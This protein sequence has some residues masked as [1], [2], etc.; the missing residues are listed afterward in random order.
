MRGAGGAIAALLVLAGC[1]A[2]RP[3]VVQLAPVALDTACPHYVATARQ[4]FD[5]N[6]RD[7]AIVGALCW[8]ERYSSYGKLQPPRAWVEVTDAQMQTLSRRSTAQGGAAALYNC[9]QQTVYFKKGF[10]PNTL[11]GYAALVHE[12]THHAQCLRYGPRSS[13]HDLCSNEIEAYDL[14]AQFVRT[15]AQ[16]IKEEPAKAKLFEAA[17]K[18]ASGGRDVCR[19][20]GVSP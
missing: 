8:L 3:T 17:V 10:A 2:D 18:V 11:P 12:L 5:V 13:P 20:L 7:R 6:D 19:T 4:E 14:Q 15:V 9:A 16:H 1:A